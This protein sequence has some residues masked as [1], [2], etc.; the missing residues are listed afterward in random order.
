[1]VRISL[2]VAAA[3][4]LALTAC[5]AVTDFKMPGD[6]LYDLEANI[7][8]TIAVTLAGDGTGSLV[9]NLTEPLPDTG[10]DEDLLALLADGTISLTV[11]NDATGVSFDLTAGERVMSNPGSA[12]QYALSVDS[13]RAVLTIQFYNATTT[14]ATL[15]SGDTCTATIDVLDN[16]YFVDSATKPITPRSVTVS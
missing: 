5:T 4:M 16:A 12:G 2:L 13:T 8:A 6:E 1:M 11:S 9:L 14:G 7:P 10:N 15:Q 3:M